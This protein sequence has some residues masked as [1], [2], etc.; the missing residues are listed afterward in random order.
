M[1]RQRIDT[2]S[3]IEGGEM[4]LVL[5]LGRMMAVGVGGPI[6]W[7]IEMSKTQYKLV[8]TWEVPECS[9][10]EPPNEKRR[11]PN[12]DVLFVRMVYSD[13]EQFGR[14]SWLRYLNDRRTYQ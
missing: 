8:P 14:P 4:K 10:D 3:A 11:C 12:C 1:G 2:A 6:A 9:H 13:W 7:W 5:W